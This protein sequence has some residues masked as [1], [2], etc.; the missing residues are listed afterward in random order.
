MFRLTLPRAAGGQLAGSPLPL[1]P[2][3]A[4]VVQAVADGGV[5][6]PNGVIPPGNALTTGGVVAI[7][8]NPQS[9][10]EDRDA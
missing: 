7:L 9:A 4:D 1:G 10:A 6:E 5:V 2:A 8:V 3:G